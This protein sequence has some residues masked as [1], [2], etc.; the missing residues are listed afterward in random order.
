MKTLQRIDRRDGVLAEAYEWGTAG[1]AAEILRVA[2]NMGKS[3]GDFRKT[4]LDGQEVATAGGIYRLVETD[5]GS[6]DPVGAAREHA[7]LAHAE[8]MGI[9]L[10]LGSPTSLDRRM[11]F[12]GWDA[13]ML[14][15][16]AAVRAERE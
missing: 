13:A 8:R 10:A 5:S 16:A 3:P 15:A 2:A 11:F 6:T 9:I 1:C 7:W 4:L 14:A 12:A